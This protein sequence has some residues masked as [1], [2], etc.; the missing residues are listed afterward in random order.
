M[1]D[2]QSEESGDTTARVCL[3]EGMALLEQ[4]FPRPIVHFTPPENWMNDPNGLLFVEGVYHLFYQY[5]PTGLTH[6]NICWGHATSPDLVTWTHLPIAIPSDE[7]EWVYSGS[8][9]LDAGN[10]AGFGPG[11]LVALYTSMT[12]DNQS[13]SIAYSNDGGATWEKYPKNPVLSRNSRDFRDPKVFRYEDKWVMVAVEAPERRVLFYQS[14]DLKEWEYL[15]SF[16]PAGAIGGVWE[17]PDLF[18]LSLEDGRTLWVLLVSMNPGGVA[19]GSATQYFLGTFDGVEFVP[20]ENA[21][22]DEFGPVNWIDWGRDCYAGVTFS[23]LPPDQRVF[24]AWMSNWDYAQTV[25]T[26]PWRGAMTIARCLTLKTVSG[27]PQLSAEPITLQAEP[28]SS[29]EGEVSGAEEIRFDLPVAARIDMLIRAGQSP[30]ILEV[31]EEGS[32]VRAAFTLADERAS[33]V[34]EVRGLTPEPGRVVEE[35]SAPLPRGL[36]KLDLTLIVDT[37]SVEAFVAQGTRVLTN[38]VLFEGGKRSAVLRSAGGEPIDVDRFEIR[39]LAP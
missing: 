15:S 1:G 31:E 13:Q 4:P 2:S 39:S 27:V 21:G 10:T 24:I 11:A 7:K 6:G 14:E 22:D 3:K 32:P 12:G 36:E 5:N 28:V 30:L 26:S 16:G 29:F 23:N 33:C 18:P 25:G 34:R 38:L 8:A 37:G 17:C 19:E 35:T 20:L 9:V